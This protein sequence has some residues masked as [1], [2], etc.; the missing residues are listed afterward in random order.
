MICDHLSPPRQEH[1]DQGPSEGQRH[2]ESPMGSDSQPALFATLTRTL[3]MGTR[4]GNILGLGCRWAH[5]C[6]GSK[7]V[8]ETQTDS[9]R[10]GSL[11]A[12]RVASG[13]SSSSPQALGLL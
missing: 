13:P 9:A 8:E 12:T 5:W 2:G 3:F 4:A 1:G 6:F 10:G 11:W 7:V